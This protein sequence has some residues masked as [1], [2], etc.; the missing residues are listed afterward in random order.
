[1]T[2]VIDNP[3]YP[4][5]WLGIKYL[6]IRAPKVSVIGIKGVRNWDGIFLQF[7]TPF[8]E[9]IHQAQPRL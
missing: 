6:G 2:P 5:I 8:F 4:K 1:M 7:P 9:D 3:Y